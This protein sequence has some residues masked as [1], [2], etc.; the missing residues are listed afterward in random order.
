M[1][2]WQSRYWYI[3]IAIVIAAGYALGGYL[4]MLYGFPGEQQTLNVAE[5]AY[6]V[7]LYS[8]GLIGG[9]MHCSVF[10][11]KDANKKMYGNER[12]PTVFDLFGYALQIIG[13]GFTGIMLY[14]AFKAGLVVFLSGD[15]QASMSNYAAWLIALAGGFG[16]HHVK[17]FV[18][19]FVAGATKNR[20][21][22]QASSDIYNDSPSTETP[23][24]QS[25]RIDNGTT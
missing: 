5:Q 9:S 7:T 15:S 25:S 14:L 3:P 17:Q 21:A 8:L 1:G 20:D 19:R 18:S 23:S 24:A 11:A 4:W 10:F 16:T 22:D 6:F 12:L 2:W 13:G